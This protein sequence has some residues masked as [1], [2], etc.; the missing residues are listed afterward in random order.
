MQSFLKSQ[1]QFWQPEPEE[2][3]LKLLKDFIS[4]NYIDQY[5]PIDMS[6][7]FNL[8]EFFQLPLFSGVKSDD[9]Y[10]ISS[11]DLSNYLHPYHKTFQAIEETKAIKTIYSETEEKIYQMYQNIL[12]LD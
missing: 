5:L 7:I 12:K 8:E 1:F 11:S 4:Q 9:H 2:Y 6:N 10:D 3:Y